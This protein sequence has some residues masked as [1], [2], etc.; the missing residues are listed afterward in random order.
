VDQLLLSYS[1]SGAAGLKASLTLLVVSVAAHMG[2]L[3][4]N[5]SMAWVGSSWVMWIAIALTLI[6]FA[7]DKIPGVDHAVHA[8]HTLLA[9]II[10]AVT[11]LTGYHGDASLAVLP[12]MLGGGNALLVHTA[13][14]GTRVAT[15]SATFGTG[16]TFVSLAE[17]FIAVLFILVAFVAPVLTALVLVLFTVWAVRLARRIATRRA[18]ASASPRR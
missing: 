14:A 10:G 13:R 17:D 11:A 12:A 1:L 9:P 5:A 2:W 7:A 6:D 16:N 15:T 3:H 8:V 4:P 18:A